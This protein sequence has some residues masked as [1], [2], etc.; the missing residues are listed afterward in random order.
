MCAIEGALIEFLKY[1]EL[2]IASIDTFKI[3]LPQQ[4]SRNVKNCFKKLAY[5]VIK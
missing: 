5:V 3:G 1:F 2:Y 4:N